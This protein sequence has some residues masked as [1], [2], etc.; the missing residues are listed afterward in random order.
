MRRCRVLVMDEFERIIP[1]EFSC[2]SLITK[3][4]SGFA[5]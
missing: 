5:V 4:A 2:A 1:K 3:R